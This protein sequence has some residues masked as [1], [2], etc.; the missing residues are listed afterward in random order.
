ME[1]CGTDTGFSS[2]DI[3]SIEHSIK[4]QTL[5]SDSERTQNEGGNGADE[6]VTESTAE[7]ETVS[8]TGSKA[9]P[10]S[11]MDSGSDGKTTPEDL[12]SDSPFFTAEELFQPESISGELG[13]SF[14]EPSSLDSSNVPL[15]EV[16]NETVNHALNPPVS[17][18]RKPL[19][20][21]E[22]VLEQRKRVGILNRWCKSYLP[23]TPLHWVYVEGLPEDLPMT[24]KD[25]KNSRLNKIIQ[26]HNTYYP[27]ISKTPSRQLAVD[28]IILFLFGATHC[29]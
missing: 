3:E 26:I 20:V 19:M 4:D 5:N 6:P 7:A 23:M 10:S 17:G 18:K 16:I 14:T 9:E 1:Q 15:S 25:L 11:E 28:R 22:D 13:L 27:H 8:E 24:K 2:G 12:S 21:L 29:E